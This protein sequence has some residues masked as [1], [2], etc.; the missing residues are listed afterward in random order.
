MITINL[1][2]YGLLIFKLKLGAKFSMVRKITNLLLVVDTPQLST[3][4]NSTSLEEF[5][6]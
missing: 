6:N 5:L 2:T 3:A 1:M 4:T